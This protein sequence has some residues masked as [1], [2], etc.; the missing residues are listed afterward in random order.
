MISLPE[1]Q[2][3]V[4]WVKEARTEGAQLKPA[5]AEVGISLRTV[6][7]WET[8]PGLQGDARPDAVRPEPVHKL[9]AEER[10]GLLDVCHEPRFADLP[11]SQIVPRLADEGVYLA[12]ESTF[13]RVLRAANEQHHRGRSRTPRAASEPVRYFAKQKNEIWSWDITYLPSD[14]KGQYDY[15]YAVLDLFS[16]KLVAWEVHAQESGE[17]AAT[18]I[19]KASWREQICGKPLILHADNGAAMKAHTLKAK[20]ESLGIRPSHSR[21]SVSDDNAHIEAWFR[22]CKYTAGYPAGGFVSLEAARNWVHG[23][24]TWYNTEHRHSGIAFV[25]PEQRHR[26]E[27]ETI[28][29]NRQAVYRAAREKHPLRWRRSTRLWQAPAVLWLNPPSKSEQRAVAGA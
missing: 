23:F 29:A 19:E 21:P 1:R 13:Y 18:L 12:S 10:Q 14:V 20:L 9:S 11:P 27:D 5:C 3:L 17:D 26:G 6:E 24:V 25:T 7:R 16:R 22:T 8:P 2:R 4:E 15:L 28:L